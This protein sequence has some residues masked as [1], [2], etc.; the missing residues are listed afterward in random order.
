MI[1]SGALKVSSGTFELNNGSLQTT[2]ISI[3]L[4]GIFLVEHGT[5]ALS[6]PIAND[7]QFVVESNGTLVDITGALLRLGIVYASV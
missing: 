6:A 3:G 4:A 2:L 5:H 7:G 1:L